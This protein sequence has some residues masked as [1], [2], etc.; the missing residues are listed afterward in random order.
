MADIQYLN[1]GD[2]QIEQQALLNNLANQVQDYVGKQ[3]WSNKRKEKFMSAYSDLMNRGI[4]GA[5]NSTGQWVINVGGDSPVPLDT[6]SRKDREMYQEAAYFIQ[7][8][9]ASLPTKASQEEKEETDKSKLPIFDH[10]TFKKGFLNQVSN[11]Y[12][13]GDNE[14][15]TSSWDE[16]DKRDDKGIRGRT[17]RAKMLIGSLERYAQNLEQNKDKYNF[18]GSPFGSL[19]E[20]KNRIAAARKALIETPDD[21]DDDFK[22]LNALGLNASEWF[23]NGS[24]DPSGQYIKLADG[25]QRQLSYA[26]LNEYNQEQA[27][28][29]EEENAKLLKKKQQEAYN[30]TLFLNRVTNPKMQGWNSVALKEKYKDSNS[31]LSALQGY[32]QKDIRTLTPDEQSEVHGAYKNLANEPIDNDLLNKIK[33]SS[34]GL[35]KNAAPNRFRKIKGIDNLIWDSIAKQV[36]QINTRQ[37]QQAVQNQ[38]QDLFAGV[39]TKA[40]IQNTSRGKGFELTDADK[41]DIA[42][43]IA[44]L[45]AFINPEMFSGTAMALSASGLRTWN[46]IEQEGLWNTLKDWKTWAD[47][48]TGLLG[49][50]AL[51]G[52]AS[53]IAKFA[54]GFGKLMTIPAIGAAFANVPEAKAAWDKIDSNN[55]VESVKKLTPQDYHALSSVLIGLLSGK[56]Y[57]KGNLAERKVL[58]ESG[59]N[60]KSASKRREILNKY[61][62]TRTKA[63]NQETV[64][65]LKVK[66]ND[67][68]KEI[69]LNPEQQRRIQESVKKAGNSEEARNKVIKEE[70]QGKEHI[71]TNGEKVKVDE[72]TKVVVIQPNK[73]LDKAWVPIRFGNSNKLFGTHQQSAVRDESKNFENWLNGRSKWEQW[74]PWSLGTNSNLRR[75]HNNIFRKDFDKSGLIS[76]ASGEESP[77]AK[78]PLEQGKVKATN[79]IEGLPDK[80]GARETTLRREIMKRYQNIMDGKFSNRDI[81]GGK[82]SVRIGDEEVRVYTSKYSDGT[83]LINISTSK[84]NHNFK[85]QEEA[86]KF[87]A[88]IVKKKKNNITK[89]PINKNTVKEIGK[90]LQDL[91]RK[92]WLREGGKIDKQRI[93]KYKEFINK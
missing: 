84:G 73:F 28:I 27:K 59:I 35:Y 40:E 21:T 88:S 30:N 26:E 58:Q 91:K 89:G 39:Q 18:E 69:T 10:S 54:R 82:E 74:K 22:A 65:T 85:S 43:T 57:I 53:S 86:K 4:Q 61:G 7:Q 68:D 13:G 33:N 90:I 32:A 66:I 79:H 34:S 29:K 67:S 56:N 93:Q 1:Y 92:G 14:I 38:P 11:D 19:D 64:P 44:D 78:K 16:Y 50:T 31:L 48:G 83:P 20:F 47:W 8:Q 23:N 71:T 52:D 76:S 77:Y 80:S 24:G 42:A 41:R 12:F 55:L 46:S 37:Q 17:E 72:N 51:L 45:G 63:S 6:M 49:G 5:S 2:Q 9:M 3:S 36:I 60:T 81:Q 62:L 15:K 87:I 70:L 75:I 25:T